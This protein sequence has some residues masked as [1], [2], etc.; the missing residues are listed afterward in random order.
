MFEIACR[1]RNAF[2]YWTLAQQVLGNARNKSCLN[3]PVGNRLTML[4]LPSPQRRL[5]TLHATLAI[6][7]KPVDAVVAKTDCRE[8]NLH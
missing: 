3:F 7:C 6:V 5:P 4:Q 1:H 8:Q 2:H